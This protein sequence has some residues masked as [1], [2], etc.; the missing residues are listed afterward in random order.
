MENKIVHVKANSQGL[1]SWISM[2]GEE[3]VGHIYMQIQLD[4]KI[5]FL[6][7]W[8]HPD[9]RR[10]GIYRSLW[11]ARWDYVNENYKNYLVYAWCKDN[12]LPLLLEKGFDLG[13]KVTY[14]EKKI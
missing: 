9:Y 7:A 2:I 14:V 5:K 10:M 8:V 12:S 11:E 3:V 13:E 4:N 6:D 1:D